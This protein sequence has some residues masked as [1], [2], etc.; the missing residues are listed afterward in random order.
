MCQQICLK[1]RGFLVAGN[2][3]NIFWCWRE[4]LFNIFGVFLNLKNIITFS[5]RFLHRSVLKK[6]NFQ[7]YYLVTSNCF[8]F[9]YY[10]CTFITNTKRV[11][12]WNELPNGSTL[13]VYQNLFI[14]IEHY[15]ISFSSSLNHLYKR[16]K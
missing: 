15:I 2:F 3:E 11:C 13:Y 12:V 5:L 14:L 4:K 8:Y 10:L 9:G 1:C 6:N 16:L 7:S